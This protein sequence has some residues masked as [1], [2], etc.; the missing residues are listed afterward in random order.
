MSY[1]KT[2]CFLDLPSLKNPNLCAK[3]KGE[4]VNVSALFDK[5]L[6]A[7]FYKCEIAS[8]SFVLA[9]LCKLSD[10]NKFKDFDEGYLSA[11]SCLGEEEAL[12]ILDFL[13]G[14]KTIIYDKNLEFYKDFESVKYFLNFLAQ[15]F[16]LQILDSDEKEQ[17]FSKVEFKALKELDNYD[18]LVLFRI[19]TGDEFL[20][21]SKQFLQLAKCQNQA[22]VQ[23]KAQSLNLQTQLFL[24]PNLQGT[25]AF[26]DFKEPCFDFV[27]IQV[28]EAQ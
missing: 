6:K 12:E 8:I 26:F 2:L 21:C 22:K 1:E 14:A 27:K 4:N 15:K 9:L 17:D 3:L 18:G 11:E 5:D 13:K 25:I 23:I 19:K 24:D 10:E 28:K 16:K 20:H 7:K